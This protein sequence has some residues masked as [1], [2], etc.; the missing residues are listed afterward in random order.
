M[1]IIASI[2][3]S[4]INDAKYVIA[5]VAQ[6]IYYPDIT[7][8]EF[9]KILDDEHE[10]DDVDNFQT[11]YGGAGGLFLAVLDEGR[12]VIG[13]GAIKYVS[14]ETAELKRLWLL[15]QFH[16]RAIGY[17]VVLK[18]FEFART[19]GYRRVI[20]QTG[21]MQHR[22]IAF[23]RRLGFVDIP[24]YNEDHLDTISMEFLL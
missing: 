17:Q 7:A 6:R 18:L 2:Q 21:I 13:T 16:G 23:Y 1:P 10:L 5:A 12:K 3:P 20:L 11:V 19:Y 14:D 8:E 9:L 24:A 4:Q 15:E 22:A